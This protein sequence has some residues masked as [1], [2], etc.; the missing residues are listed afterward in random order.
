MQKLVTL[1]GGTL[2]QFYIA[3]VLYFLRNTIHLYIIFLLILV[4]SVVLILQ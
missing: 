3:G 2:I 1:P 4:G